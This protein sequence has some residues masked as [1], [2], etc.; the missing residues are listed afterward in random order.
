[1]LRSSWRGLQKRGP[2]R[3][4]LQRGILLAVG[5]WVVMA[6]QKNQDNAIANGKDGLPATEQLELEHPILY[7]PIHHL[8][9]QELASSSS[10]ER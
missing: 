6:R 2:W 4:G 10:A 8:H 1:M 7:S 9:P 3:D 5:F